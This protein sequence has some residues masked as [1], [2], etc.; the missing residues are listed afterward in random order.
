MRVSISYQNVNYGG[1][2][3]LATPWQNFFSGGLDSFKY[4]VSSTCMYLIVTLLLNYNYFFHDYFTN[5]GS[6]IGT[7]LE[8]KKLYYFSS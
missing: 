7:Q 1:L 5:K 4:Y 6:K 2:F 8:Y 3:I